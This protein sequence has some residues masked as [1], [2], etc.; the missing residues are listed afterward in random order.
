[1]RTRLLRYALLA[2]VLA[3]GA[4][5]SGLRYSAL[6]ETSDFHRATEMKSFT[7]EIRSPWKG[8]RLELKLRVESGSVTV[9][10]VD[11]SGTTRYEKSF[12]AG[13]SEFQQQFDGNGVWNIQLQF[14]DAT[15]R[16][17]VGL[18]GI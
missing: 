11:P 17:D 15:G 10:L 16:Y 14:H 5:G 7:H 1:M 3:S 4:W 18:V 8:A 6:H 12:A 2:L 13:K 9:K